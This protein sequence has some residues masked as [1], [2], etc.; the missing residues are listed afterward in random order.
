MWPEAKDYLW[1][2]GLNYMTELELMN[3]WKIQKNVREQA[4]FL[5]NYQR[6]NVECWMQKHKPWV[7]FFSVGLQCRLVFKIYRFSGHEVPEGSSAEC[8]I[9]TCMCASHFLSCFLPSLFW[10]YLSSCAPLFSDIYLTN[11]QTRY[12]L[13]PISISPQPISANALANRAPPWASCVISSP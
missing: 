6:G 11:S 7:S 2:I 12:C 13:T 3:S 10:S 9:I 8:V 4:A 1:Q 5:T